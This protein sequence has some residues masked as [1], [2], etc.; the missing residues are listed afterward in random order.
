MKV[1]LNFLW[2]IL[3][4]WALALSYLI[5]GVIACVFVVTI[6]FG[7]ACFRMANFTLWPF[8]RTVIEP[9]HGTGG[10]SVVSNVIWFCVAGV[11]IAL[12][13]IATALAQAVTIVG[14]PFAWANLKML[15][16]M[17]VP[18]GRRIADS[19]AIP[20]GWRPMV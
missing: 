9:V 19:D 10:V 20:A 18:F 4:G 16:V 12:S 15:P 1:L 6:P 3:G 8:G 7:V 5:F 14:I 11:W 13:H 17:V 2:F